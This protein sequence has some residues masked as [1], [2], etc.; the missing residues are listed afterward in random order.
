MAAT[1]RGEGNEGGKGKARRSFIR[2]HAA[3]QGKCALGP[4]NIGS[5]LAE[6]PQPR[7][8]DLVVGD[9]LVFQIAR[10]SRMP[11]RRAAVIRSSRVRRGTNQAYC[12]RSVSGSLG[13]GGAEDAVAAF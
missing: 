6:F 7:L 3:A 8:Y 12:D 9:L 5:D 2:H 11:S 1:K 13:S 4:F 10:T